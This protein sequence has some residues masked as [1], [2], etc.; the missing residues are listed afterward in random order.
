MILTRFLNGDMPLAV[1]AKAR[2]RDK[3]IIVGEVLLVP[4]AVG[5]EAASEGVQ[6][7]PQKGMCQEAKST[8]GKDPPRPKQQTK[9]GIH[10]GPPMQKRPLRQEVEREPQC[11]LK[12]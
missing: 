3:A 12:S 4:H 5:V 8:T 2:D 1:A 10:P 6:G 9:Y 7:D 11:S